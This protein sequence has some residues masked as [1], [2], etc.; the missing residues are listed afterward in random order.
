METS[1][2]IIT[3]DNT[4]IKH[5]L[6]F[7][8]YLARIT[9]NEIERVTIGESCCYCEKTELEFSDGSDIKI[10]LIEM[11]PDCNKVPDDRVTLTRMNLNCGERYGNIYRPLYTPLFSNIHNFNPLND[12]SPNYYIDPAIENLRDYNDYIR[13][14]ELI[15]D[16]LHDIFKVVSPEEDNLKSF[17]NAIRN[18]LILSCTEVDSLMKAALLDGGFNEEQPTMNHY[19]HLIIPMNL[20]EYTLSFRNNTGIGS[21]SPFGNWTPDDSSK[22]LIWYK[23]YNNVKHNRIKYFKE[24]NLKNAINATLGFATM[25]IA[26]FGYRN[27]IWREKISR[28]IEIKKEP[29]WSLKDFYIP[30]TYG[31]KTLYVL[32]PYIKS[33]WVEYQ[34]EKNNINI[35]SQI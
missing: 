19:R 11:V 12:I 27:D 6:W 18:V 33:K 3:T 1:T 24:A 15:L 35:E 17:G 13:Q 8:N 22:S 10:K 4:G 30:P 9:G 2:F 28:L 32:H 31:S 26:S 29:L 23:A 5:H 34:K 25:L 21:R 7:Y 14:L 16:E 20:S